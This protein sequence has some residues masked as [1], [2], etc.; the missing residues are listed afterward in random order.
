MRA[1]Y[2]LLPWCCSAILP[3]SAL[4][5]EAKE[6]FAKDS[7][8]GWKTVSGAEPRPGGWSMV[9]GVLTH[10]Q[11]GC[12]DL[13]SVENYRDFELT[14]EWRVTEAANSGV[15]YRV[16][17]KKNAPL[18]FEYQVLDDAKHK[19]GSNPR[20]SA[21]A[22]YHT[23]APASGKKLKP[24][25]DWNEAKIVVRGRHIEHW[26]NGE[27]VVDVEAK[28]AD[29]EAAVKTSKYAKEPDYGVA[30]SGPIVIQDHND[31]VSFRNM[32]VRPL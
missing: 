4:A 28:G 5:T 23:I 1:L 31:R 32:K 6:L 13:W 20:T 9:D 8:A 12:G 18:G 2:F 27:K 25:G 29:W 16:L 11:L 10:E 19:D 17:K 7:L 14:F 21:A 22:L 24:V 3:F 26:L 15:K 30:E